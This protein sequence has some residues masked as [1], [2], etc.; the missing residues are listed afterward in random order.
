MHHVKPFISPEIPHVA[1]E[2][3]SYAVD[4]HARRKSCVVNLHAMDVIRDEKRTPALVRFAVVRQ[5]FEI[6]LDYAG[7]A[8]SFC[9]AQ[10]EAVLVERTGRSVPK[11]GER[12]RGEAE[13][14]SLRDR[15]FSA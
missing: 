11:F 4:I 6:P 10:A 14:R 8:V 7:Q 15:T 9:Y 12:L 13:A 2:E 1:R 5:K 3:C